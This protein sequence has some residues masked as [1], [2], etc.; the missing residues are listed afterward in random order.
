[1]RRFSLAAGW[2]ALAVG[3]FLP[4]TSHA[5]Q[6]LN[7]TFGAFLPNGQDARTREDRGRSGDVLLSN[8]DFLSFDL[9][10]FRGPSLGME[11]VV[12]VGEYL[13]AGLGVGLYRQTIPS[14]YADYVNRNGVEIEQELKLRMV[15]WTATV[16]V[17]PFGRS[18][19]IE[20]YLGAGVAIVNWRY[21]EAGEFVDFSDGS[22]FRDSYVGS[23]TAT[24]P[25]V[26]GGVMIPAG[27][28]GIGYETRW[29]RVR[30]DLPDDLGFATTRD[31]QRAW[32]DLG[33]WSHVARLQV[34]F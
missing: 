8:L 28:W 21:S 14:V 30:A 33:G 22:I 15:P 12:G 27:R 2:L 10:D 16:R 31:G 3:V 32:V 9:D 6:S 13:D 25:T 17:L 29:Q 24:G 1:M 7:F 26:L 19:A 5:Q 20:P 23:G 11:Y 34:R 4:A 18:G